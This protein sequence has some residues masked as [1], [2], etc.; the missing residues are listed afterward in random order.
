MFETKWSPNEVRECLDEFYSLYQKRPIQDNSGG[1]KSAH[2]LNAWF[3]VKTLKP[4]FLIE[5]G[6]FEGQGTWFF[7]KASPETQ[8]ISIDPL[9]AQRYYISDKVDYRTHDFLET[10]WSGIDKDN[11]FIFFDDHQNFFERFKHCCETGF[12]RLA[13][14]DNYP[15]SQ[16]DC[17]TP[18]K[19]LSNK[20][21]VMDYNGQRTWNEKNDDDLDYLNKNM[22]IYQEMNPIFGDNFTR[23]GDEWEM[24]KYP[25]N[26]PLLL[27]EQAREYPVYFQERRDYTWICY[28]ETH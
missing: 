24:N 22:K 25:T 20:N 17:Y 15:Y 23:W 16:G 12:K 18:K 13:W 10:D 8:I 6:I 19:I 4:K 26:L 28:I 14:E 21:W 9:L 7:E 2:M 5:S 1:M 3:M 11:T 27:P